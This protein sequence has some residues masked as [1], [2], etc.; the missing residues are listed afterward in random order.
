MSVHSR[1]WDVYR[2]ASVILGIATLLWVVWYWI[3]T[4]IF[5]PVTEAAAS[6]GAQA[7]AG[8]AGLQVRASSGGG[9]DAMRARLEQLSEREMKLLYARCSRESID[10]RL[11]G[12]EA[13]ACS[14]AYDV[15][16]TMHFGGDFQ[17][18]LHWSRTNSMP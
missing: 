16:L 6:G 13:L 3:A 8:Q 11:D 18:F 1:K 12:A 2:D 14:I 5:E 15:L 4:A 7:H 9:M 17:T 10:R